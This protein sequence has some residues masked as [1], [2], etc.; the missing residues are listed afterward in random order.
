MGDV[1]R[2]NLTAAASEVGGSINIGTGVETSVLDL[3]DALKGLAP[4]AEL[5]PTFAPPRAGEVTRSALDATRARQQLGWEATTSLSDGLR[6]T[7]EA[8]TAG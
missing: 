8:A 3:L 1:V 6:H 5:D 7:L 4:N 2:A